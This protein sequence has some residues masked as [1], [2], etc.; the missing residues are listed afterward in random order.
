MVLCLVDRG[1]A[2]ARAAAKA[3]RELN[4]LMFDVSVSRQTL[5]CFVV[6]EGVVGFETRGK[7]CTVCRGASRRSRPRS[8]RG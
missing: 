7:C 5:L 1:A 6:P 4:S 2:G 3:E 8:G